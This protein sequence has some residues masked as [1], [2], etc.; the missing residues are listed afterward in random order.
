[1]VNYRLLA[2]PLLLFFLLGLYGC[3]SDKVIR[4][5]ISESSYLVAALSEKSDQVQMK[6]TETYFDG[7][8]L[9]VKYL[10]GNQAYYSEGRWEDS[11]DFAV[12]SR[13]KTDTIVGELVLPLEQNDIRPWKNLSEDVDPVL[14]LGTEVWDALM[15]QVVDKVLP[16]APFMGVIVDVFT[17]EYFLYSDENNRSRIT[18]LAGKPGRIGIDRVWTFSQLLDLTLPYLENYLVKNGIVDRQVLLNTG[19]SGLYSYPFI[20]ADMDKNIVLFAEVSPTSTIEQRLGT[21]NDIRLLGH[22]IG[23]HAAIIVRPITSLGQLIYILGDLSFDLLESGGD[24]IGTAVKKIFAGSGHKSPPPLTQ[25]S[26]MDLEAFEKRL[27]EITNSRTSWGTM[28]YLVDGVEFFPRL[29]DTMSQAEKTIH[30]RIYIFDNDDYAITIADIL[31]KHSEKV[32][33]KVLIDGAGTIM[34]TRVHAR[35][36][37]LAHSPPGSIKSYLKQ[38]SDVQVRTQTNPWFTADHSKLIIID[39]KTAFVGGMNIGREYRY[40]RHDIMVQLSGPVVSVLQGEFDKAWAHAGVT[41]DVGLFAKALETKRD[42]QKD[43]EGYPIRVLVSKAGESEIYRTQLEAI[44]QAKNYIYLENMY[45]M[46][47]KILEELVKAR[48]RGV[49][50]RVIIS[51]DEF[52]WPINRAHTLVANMLIENGIRVYVYPGILHAKAAVYDGWACLGSANFDKAS[53]KR[54]KEL[55]VATSHKGAVDDLLQRFFEPD[56]MISYELTEPVQENWTDRIA[57]ML[58]DQL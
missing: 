5:E 38:R 35:T 20:Y 15:T 30:F 39:A 11:E 40:E 47:D 18:N 13:F 14:V 58:T 29:L 53:F 33:V 24:L 27:D 36:M 25:R 9:F 3:M 49:D 4:K 57:E 21:E 22:F 43:G 1:M 19:D 7:R 54:N 8:T 16:S 50:V 17:R 56:F 10:L 55:N 32:E 45:Y 51:L 52:T 2:I 46:Q 44:R 26:G 48:M 23:S 37:P 31:R 12:F 6:A 28:T 41:G 34:A 42:D